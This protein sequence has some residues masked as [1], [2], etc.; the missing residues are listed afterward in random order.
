M[1]GDTASIDCLVAKYLKKTLNT[2]RH[3]LADDF[4]QNNY[5]LL[6]KGWQ[7]P[8]IFIKSGNLEIQSKSGACHIARLALRSLRIYHPYQ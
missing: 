8:W 5:S 7:S 4:V 3:C 6:Q 2:L 1:Q